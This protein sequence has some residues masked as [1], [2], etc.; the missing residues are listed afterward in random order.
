VNFWLFMAIIAGVVILSGVALMFF[1]G[2]KR[3]SPWEQEHDENT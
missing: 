2:S 3:P 1:A